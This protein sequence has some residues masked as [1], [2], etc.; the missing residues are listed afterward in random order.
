VLIRSVVMR[1]MARLGVPQH[2][3]Q[4]CALVQVD[5]NGPNA[6]PVWRFLLAHQPANHGYP[7][8]IDWNFNK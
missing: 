1:K 5:V 7:T 2:M 3:Y 8:T 4:M 6:H